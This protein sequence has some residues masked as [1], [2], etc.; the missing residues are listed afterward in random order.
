MKNANSLFLQDFEKVYSHSILHNISDCQKTFPQ[1][2]I[3]IR[4][5][6]ILPVFSGNVLG[7]MLSSTSAY[8][9]C[10]DLR[11]STSQFCS[12]STIEALGEN[13]LFCV[14]ILYFIGKCLS[15]YSDIYLFNILL[16]CLHLNKNILRHCHM[17]SEGIYYHLKMLPH[18]VV[19]K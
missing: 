18:S 1:I 19:K 16:Q 2:Q 15:P 9:K 6:K 8:S 3:S 5:I 10:W 17:H 13:F 12:S 7:K 4:Y 11:V 14:W